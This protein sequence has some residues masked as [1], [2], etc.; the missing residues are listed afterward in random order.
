MSLCLSTTLHYH[1]PLTSWDTLQV[2]PVSSR[3]G[4]HRQQGRTCGTATIAT[5]FARDDESA[6][7]RSQ[8]THADYSRDLSV[9]V[10][11][12]SCRGHQLMATQA[13]RHR[14]NHDE[15][16]Q[17]A[18]GA[19]LR[20]DHLRRGAQGQRLERAVGVCPVAVEGAR[21]AELT[22]FRHRTLAC[23]KQL[24]GDFRLLLTGTPL[25]CSLK[26]VL[27]AVKSAVLMYPPCSPPR[28]KTTSPNSTPSS[29]PARLQRPGPVR[30]AVRLLR[31]HHFGRVQALRAGRG[32]AARCAAAEYSQA[33]LA[34]SLQEGRYQGPP[35]QEGVRAD[36]PNVKKYSRT[37]RFLLVGMS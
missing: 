37:H 36:L 35:P 10:P 31:D 6:T 27:R 32:D 20:R 23:L 3:T 11:F 21:A 5:R 26:H 4:V 9:H 7:T 30:V 24:K 25:V 18:Q 28:S 12:S 17:L 15:R 34:P 2:R 29:P 8:G 13:D 19:Q 1:I 14:S 33:V 22:I 16:Y